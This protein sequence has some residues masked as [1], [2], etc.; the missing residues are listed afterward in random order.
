M[1]LRIHIVAAALLASVIAVAWLAFA[2]R[3]YEE[4]FAASTFFAIVAL[5]LPALMARIAARRQG[6]KPTG[7]RE[8]SPENGLETFTGRLGMRQAATQV[9]LAPGA[10]AIG[11]AAI[12]LV[13]IVIRHS[14]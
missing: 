4:V 12:A 10:V 2:T 9:L 11:F 1:P 13:E 7:A 5:G 3:R 8:H 14:G 6:S